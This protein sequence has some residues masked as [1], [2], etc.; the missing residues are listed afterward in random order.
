VWSENNK[1]P[2]KPK[3]I[4]L[5]IDEFRKLCG[6]CNVSV[7]ERVLE[8][9]EKNDLL[10]PIYR[11]H[12][13]KEYLQKIFEHK[14]SPDHAKAIE[15]PDE[16]GS[17]LKFDEESD[18]WKHPI[19]PEFDK[20][21]KEGHPLDQAYKRGEPFIEKPSKDI[22]KNWRE[23]EI[24][25][26]LAYDGSTKKQRSSTAFFYYSP[27]QIYFVEEANRKHI[28]RINVLMPLGEGEKYVFSE[29][30][31]KLALTEWQDH[32]KM[33]WEYRFKENLYFEKALEGSKNNILEGA[34][35][36]QFHED[37]NKV[38]IGVCSHH[39]Y[40]SWIEF[41]KV[42][43]E[44]YF[45]YQKRE[46]YKLSNCLKKDIRG[47]IDILMYG[48]GKTY[49]DVINDV[50]MILG[51]RTYFDVSPL[52]R[53]YPEYESYLKRE[54]KLLLESLLKDYNDEVPN[55]LKLSNNA[56]EEIVEQA[57]NSG[58]ETL[59]IS[60]IGINK[61]YFSPSYFGDEGIWS[62][63]RSLATAVESWVKGIASN[64]NFNNALAILTKGDFDSCCSKL[65]TKCGKTNLEVNNYADLKQFLTE[66]LVTRLERGGRDLSWMQYIIR[67]YLIRNY[68]AH[69]T[70]LAPEL[71]GSTLI[72]LYKSLLFLVFY[73]WKVK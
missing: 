70:R 16:Y 55:S 37:C 33:L 31:Q 62:Y 54:S 42:L 57:S 60:V 59:L 65:K 72:E 29:P 13:P 14:Y 30:A 73:A 22:F 25:L 71:L 36:K 51:S 49:R 15:V 11:L 10:Y 52:E 69:H 35:L 50:G 18:K 5:E 43:C 26:E 9:Y 12:R 38:A 47:I 61:E 56:I 67:A 1:C 23:Y 58:N 19:F 68:V 40:E 46:Q 7:S 24:V 20:T 66:L 53:I 27:W 41:L 3:N 21:L 17:L 32:F 2:I 44:L 4:Y 39:P 6:E 8:S 45:D 64:N 28:C 63:V 48:F 34:D